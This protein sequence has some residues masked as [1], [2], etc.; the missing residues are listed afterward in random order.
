[1]SSIQFKT[2]QIANF[3]LSPPTPRV[4]G[5][6]GIADWLVGVIRNSQ[7]A[8]RR[9]LKRVEEPFISVRLA[10]RPPIVSAGRVRGYSA[11]PEGPAAEQSHGSESPASRASTRTDPGPADAKGPRHPRPAPPERRPPAPR[12]PRAPQ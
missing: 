10:A 7:S 9:V 5:W 12:A 4:H 3:G 2:Q 6:A 8:M 1:M 11:W